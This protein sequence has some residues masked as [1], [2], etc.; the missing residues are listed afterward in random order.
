MV[1]QIYCNYVNTYFNKLFNV[2]FSIE[3]A[4][5]YTNRP[6]FFNNASKLLK[7]NGVFVISDI[8]LKNTQDTTL[9][10][11]AFLRI[12]SDLLCIP[13]QN[14]ITTNQWQQF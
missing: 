12:A 6:Q 3:S 13:Q 2:I 5:H 11:S 10:N 1:E 14:W 4:F 8:V 9:A 7:K